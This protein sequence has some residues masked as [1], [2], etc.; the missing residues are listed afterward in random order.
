MDQ[1]TIALAWRHGVSAVTAVGLVLLT[2][3][4]EVPGSTRFSETLQNSA[5]APVFFLINLLFLR[6][7]GSRRHAGAYALVLG[8]LVG[9]AIEIAQ[10]FSGGDGEWG[11]VFH[12]MLG[13]V[14][15]LGWARWRA[16]RGAK[17]RFAL[18]AF[19]ACTA[20]AFAPLAWCVAAYARRA[21]IFPEL[22]RFSSSLD[23]YFV[24]EDSR[25][26]WVEGAGLRVP[27]S[28]G[29]WPGVALDE[30]APD[31]TGYQSLVIELANPSDEEL[32]LNVRV[33]DR[34]HNFQMSD[35][36]NARV[37]LPPQSHVA[38]QFSLDEIRRA[39]ATRLMDMRHVQS[40]IIFA[41]GQKPG[42][43]F[44]LKSVRLSNKSK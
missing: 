33:N 28:G 27:L 31:W 38:F 2:V 26:D 6:V 18:A 16:S 14:A 13:V 23:L 17:A 30:P 40:L 21:D 19:I 3:F 10:K 25:L 39:P 36:F 43:V 44:Y 29:E 42:R 24:H 20:I 5:H 37:L 7:W 32:P 11:D 1:K 8:F 12:D 34:A 4:G 35:R 41:H 15:A 9:G 22:A